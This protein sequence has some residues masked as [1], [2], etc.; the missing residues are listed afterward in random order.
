MTEHPE[1]LAEAV[2]DHDLT[3]S[4]TPG[5]LVLVVVGVWLLLR[6]IRGLRA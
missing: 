1:S 5:Q 3:L 4:L 6:F 2:E